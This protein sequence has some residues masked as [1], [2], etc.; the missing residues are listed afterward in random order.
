VRKSLKRE[1]AIPLR[2]L[3]ENEGK[4]D[5]ARERRVRAPSTHRATCNGLAEQLRAG[6]G[7]QRP[8]RVRFQPRLTPGVSAP[9]EAW[10]FLQGA[11]PC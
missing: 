3:R 2:R 4:G 9:S 6:D 11:S 5:T 7:F 8:L 1:A 10:R